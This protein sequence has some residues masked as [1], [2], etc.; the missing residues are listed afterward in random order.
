M[1]PCKIRV[2]PPFALQDRHLACDGV[3]LAS[4]A[5]HAG[6]PVYV[7]SARAVR[8]A[9]RAIDDAFAGY[10]HAMHYALKANSTLAILRLLRELGSR[11]DANSIGE[12]QVALRA[13]FPPADTV[14]TGVGKTRAELE[15]AVAAGVGAINVESPGELDRIAAIAAA[16]GAV[17][18]VAVRVNPDIDARSHPNIST[19]LKTNKFGVALDDAREIYRSRRTCGPCASSACTS[20]SDRRSPRPSRWRVPRRCWSICARVLPTDGVPLEHM[21]LGGGLGVGLRRRVQSLPP[22]TTRPRS[23]RRCGGAACPS[24]WSRGV[25]WWRR[26]V[27]WWRGSWT[28]SNTRTAGGSRCSMPA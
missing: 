10:P 27:R 3:S 25:P 24:C 14:F 26:P 9:Y 22:P 20:T 5:E 19:G 21:D 1:I 16:H 23:C 12:L 7:Y 2:H 18:R 13:G 4:I 15:V 8:E 11:A 28:R 6:T 17:A